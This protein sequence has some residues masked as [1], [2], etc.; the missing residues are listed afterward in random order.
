MDIKVNEYVK[1]ARKQGINKIIEI[2]EDGV[3]ELE[4]PI[5]DEWGEPTGFIYPKDIEDEILEHSFEL[6]DLIRPEDYIN[7]HKVYKSN[8]GLVIFN[9]DDFKYFVNPMGLDLDKYRVVLEWQDENYIKNVV[10][11]EQFDREKYVVGG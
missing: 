3:L 7:G 6:L 10:T 5:A 4:E 8:D 1:L 9:I 11:K 2:D